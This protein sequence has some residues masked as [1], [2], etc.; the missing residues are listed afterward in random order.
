M[1]NT[2]AARIVIESVMGNGERLPW[3]PAETLRVPSGM[4]RFEFQ[5]TVPELTAPS[6]LRFRYRLAGMDDDW[7][8]GNESR[9]ARYSR[10]TPGDYTFR[11]MA[12]G[13]DGVWR[14]SDRTVRLQVV[15]RLWERRG[16]QL[17]GTALLVGL[18]GGS[19]A[20]QQRRR[21]KRRLERLEM[22][23]RVADERRR[24]ARDLHDDLGAQ[25][26]A[27]ANL[28]ALAIVED[29][30]RA[31][32][33]LSRLLEAY[34]G[35]TCVAACAT[36]ADALL[37]IP[38][39]RPLVV[40]MDINLPEVQ[41]L[42]LTAYSDNEYIFEALKAGATGYLLKSISPDD[43][44]RSIREVVDGGAPMSG[45]IARQVIEVF[46]QPA[47]PGTEEA[48]LTPR[49]NE[50]LGLLAQGYSNKEIAARLDL[51]TG[52]ASVHLE[53]IYEKLHVHCRTEAA[54]RYLRGPLH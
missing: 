52:T 33:A 50:I 20:W 38:E 21:M 2:S 53:H 14:E 35:V 15:P 28:G 48:P 45:M 13:G 27:I 11:I 10:L 37:K 54:A 34:P 9:V 26:T 6:S 39:S 46:R 19:L 49:E 7:L 18:I 1:E 17:L 29:N 24:I 40:L 23:H 22:E 51:S 43:L 3:T 47:S 32:Q 8:E 31:R 12:G 4:R 16:T 36:A 44:I 5:Y 30:A 42:M 25:L 41:I